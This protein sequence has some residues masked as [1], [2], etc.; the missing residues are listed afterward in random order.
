M[1]D[2][3]VQDLLGRT[4]KSPQIIQRAN[5]VDGTKHSY[6][7]LGGASYPGRARWVDVASA[8]NDATRAAAITAGLA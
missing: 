8:A 4:D 7:V 6:Y 5:S 3:D 2:K 1:A